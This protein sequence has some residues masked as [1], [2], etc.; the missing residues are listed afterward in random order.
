MPDGMTL[1][2]SGFHVMCTASMLDW[3]EDSTGLNSLLI[4]SNPNR[5]V[6]CCNGSYINT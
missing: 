4:E 6:D 1:T 5:L 3:T 2:N